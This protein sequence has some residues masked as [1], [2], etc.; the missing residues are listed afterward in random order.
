M[1]PNR[2]GSAFSYFVFFHIFHQ[3]LMASLIDFR[4][5]LRPWRF[6]TLYCQAKFLITC[7][8]EGTR[9]LRHFVDDFHAYRDCVF[10]DN[11]IFF[12]SQIISFFFSFFF[13]SLHK[14]IKEKKKRSFTLWRPYP[15]TNSSHASI[16][17]V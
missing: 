11:S 14:K 1:T 8:T 10:G 9:R 3:P 17:N 13:L 16:D 2:S 15:L 5:H 4:F 7:R 12:G 6:L